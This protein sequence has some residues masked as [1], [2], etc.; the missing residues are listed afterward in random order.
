MQSNLYINSF[1]KKAIAV[2]LVFLMLLS[3]CSCAKLEE[4]MG[5]GG[6][7]EI[8]RVEHSG[9]QN[10]SKQE[11]ISVE[12][13]YTAEE[14]FVTAPYSNGVAVSGYT[15]TESVVKI[16]QSIGGASVLAIKAGAIKDKAG[17]ENEA[18]C[19]ITEII[20]PFTVEMIE[21]GAFSGCKELSRL[22]VPFAGGALN[23]HTYIGYLFGSVNPAGNAKDMPESLAELTVGG[24]LIHDK[25]FS[26]CE[27]V[28]SIVLTEAEAVGSSAFEN[29]TAL[30]TLVI[31]ESVTSIGENAMKGCS[32]L[33][34]L[35][36]PFIGN[37]ADKLFLGASFG[38]ADYT[39]N[40]EYVPSSLRTLTVPCPEE[41][42]VGAF[43]ECKDLVTLNLKG[44]LKTVSEKAF[45]RCRRLKYLNIQHEGYTGISSIAAY[46]FGYCA[47]LGE[48]QL[49]EAVNE[50]PDGAFYS[51]SSLRTVRVGGQENVLPATHTDIGT[52]AFAY[53]ESLPSIKL[54]DSI[55]EIKDKAFYGCAYLTEITI[56][57][58]V[59]RL[60]NQAFMGCTSMKSVELKSVGG[61][62]DIGNGAFS[63]CSSL[64][65]LTLS[66]CVTS[67][68]DNAFAYSALKE[69]AVK[70]KNVTVGENAFKGCDNLVVDVDMSSETYNN[71][72]ESGLG[73]SN[74]KN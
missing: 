67:I 39:Q 17:T 31:P 14:L 59:T 53:C 20:V 66:S 58:G 13:P 35:T 61:T 45:Y 21:H 22:T 27:N 42:P 55:T 8:S 29:C 28:K 56:P 5:I 6:G 43:Y 7:S 37:G 30:K 38:A 12:I 10:D 60:G 48:I 1:V 49:D 23:Q 50:L 16:P 64:T 24:T 19:V 34:D 44:N 69:L 18:G 52:A 51:C 62:L 2:C 72:V 71:L 36:L 33:A 74:F 3:L 68:G 11:D 41:L 4:L 46:S 73:N 63:Y 47:A 25:A 57:A 15:G 32:A 9:E 26:G 54:P 65:A 40:L 70:G